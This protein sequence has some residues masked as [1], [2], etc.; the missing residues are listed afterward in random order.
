MNFMLIIWQETKY[1]VFF[2]GRSLFHQTFQKLT[3]KC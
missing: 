1:P 3:Q 2:G